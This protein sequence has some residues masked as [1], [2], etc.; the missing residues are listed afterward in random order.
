VTSKSAIALDLLHQVR[1]IFF[2]DAEMQL[3]VKDKD[4]VFGEPVVAYSSV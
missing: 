1:Q 4:G 2:L 3:I